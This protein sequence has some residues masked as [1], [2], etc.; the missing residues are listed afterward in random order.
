M[1]LGPMGA[2]RMNRVVGLGLFFDPLPCL[3]RL[4]AQETPTPGCV[5]SEQADHNSSELM[6]LRLIIV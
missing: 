2:A 6:V 4:N 1:L 5:E 3:P